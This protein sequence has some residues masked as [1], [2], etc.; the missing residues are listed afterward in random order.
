MPKAGDEEHSHLEWMGGG[1]EIF[2]IL[3]LMIDEHANSVT[4]CTTRNSCTELKKLSVQF[5]LMTEQYQT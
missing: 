4:R 2:T 1:G 5:Y 3:K